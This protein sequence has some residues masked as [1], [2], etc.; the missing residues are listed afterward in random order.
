VGTRFKLVGK[1][2]FVKMAADCW[3]SRSCG[4]GA[5]PHDQ[6]AVRENEQ[7]VL[8][9]MLAIMAPY[10]GP[11]HLKAYLMAGGTSTGFAR[12]TP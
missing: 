1:K 6:L 5:D 2:T 11:L 8:E 4:R 10:T 12:T 3:I 9:R 7:A